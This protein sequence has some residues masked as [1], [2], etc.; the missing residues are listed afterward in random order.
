MVAVAGLILSAALALAADAKTDDAVAP[1]YSLREKTAVG[2]QVRTKA[3]LMIYGKIRAGEKEESLAGQALLEYPERVLAVA[4]TGLPSKVARFYTDARAKFVIGNGEDPRQLRGDRRL[5][6]GDHAD[7]HL[8]LWAAAGS[9]TGDERELVEDTLDTTRLPGLLPVEE[10]KIGAT[11]KP[12]AGVL[13]SLCDLDHFIASDVACTLE[14]IDAGKATVKVAGS[15]QGLSIGTEAKMKIDA[16]LTID[17][18]AKFIDEVQWTQA[19][20]RGAGP[21]SPA[22]SFLVKATLSRTKADS[23]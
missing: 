12:D 9:L 3:H 18:E 7:H 23:H 20:S 6:V 4:E 1:T 2:A 16:V 8:A 19:D 14:K 21:V 15:V 5:V 11:W 17:V 22:G 10:V 13:Q